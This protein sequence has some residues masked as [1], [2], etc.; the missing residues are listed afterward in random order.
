MVTGGNA[1]VF[2]TNMDT[3]IRF[4]TEVVGLS[5]ASHY[6]D[7]WAE[8]RAGGFTIGLH[9]R[10]EKAAAPGTHGAIQIGLLVESTAEALAK[11]DAHGVAHGEVE[12]GS[13]GS[14]VHFGDPDGNELYFWEMPKWG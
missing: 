4:Y 8:V 14:F 2:I 12:K 13:G 6:G 10:S 11:L 7:A 5:L 3:A 9:P 1:T